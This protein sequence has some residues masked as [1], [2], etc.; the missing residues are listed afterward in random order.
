LD[1]KTCYKFHVARGGANLPFSYSA[2]GGLDHELTA[3]ISVATHYPVRVRIG[4]MV[5]DFSPVTPLT[6]AIQIPEIYLAALRKYHPNL[7]P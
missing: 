4:Q 2:D 1:G 3:W 6:K 5:Y 7:L